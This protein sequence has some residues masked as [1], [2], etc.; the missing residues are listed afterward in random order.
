MATQH[1][2]FLNLLPPYLFGIFKYTY[3]DRHYTQVFKPM[4]LPHESLK[5]GYNIPHKRRVYIQAS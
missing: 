5:C 4:K 1:A 3:I 2:T